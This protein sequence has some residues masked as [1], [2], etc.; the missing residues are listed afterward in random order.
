MSIIQRLKASSL[1]T[2]TAKLVSGTAGGRL[3]LLAVLP[4]VTR[5]YDPEDFALLAVYMAL[6]TTL[7]VAACL[8]L[9]IAIP[10]A[11]TDEQAADLLV[12]S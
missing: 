6:I 9:D 12:M 11:E 4:V 5:L 7:S 8:R 1:F 10:L 2:D 3:I